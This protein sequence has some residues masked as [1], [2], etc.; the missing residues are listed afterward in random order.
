MAVR[1]ET[2][3]DKTATDLRDQAREAGIAGTSHMRKDELVASIRENEAALEKAADRSAIDV[4]V[5]DHRKVA[6]LFKEALAKDDGDPKIAE[7][8]KQIVLELELHT[9]AEEKIFYPAF[10][11]VAIEREK[12]DAKDEVLEAYV[13]HDGV[14]DLIAKL[15]KLSVKDES[16]KAILQ[17]MSEQVEHHVKE[18]EHE[19]FPTA[20]HFFDRAELHELGRAIVTMKVSGARG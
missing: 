3:E 5:E 2:L 6:A 10:K 12:D 7:L 8:A 16:Y 11:R 18:E 4:L 13:E 19:M 14:K 20:K 9:T 17:V 1:S 15:E